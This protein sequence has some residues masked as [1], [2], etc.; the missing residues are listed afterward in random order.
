V[1]RGHGEYGFARI[2]HGLTNQVNWF[3]NQG[4][5]P[6]MGWRRFVMGL[7]FSL[8]CTAGAGFLLELE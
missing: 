3:V 2:V 6:T 4:Y 5:C 8:W 1:S 7:A